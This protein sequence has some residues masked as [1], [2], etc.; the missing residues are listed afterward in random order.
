MKKK[1]FLILLVVFIF[2]QFIR[3]AKNLGQAVTNQDITHSV[4]VPANIHHILEASCYDCHSNHTNYPWYANVNP[5]GW[6]LNHHIEEGKAEI[7]FSDFS[8]YDK[9]KLDHKL[10]EIAEEVQEGHM[11]LPSYLYLHTDATLNPQQVSQL[12]SWVNQERQKLN[13]P[14]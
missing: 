12:V 14:K 9:K 10:E 5:V 3:P 4:A 1:I 2:I 13:I 6:W 7:N 8:G 11:P